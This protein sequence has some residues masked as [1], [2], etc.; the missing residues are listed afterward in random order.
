MNYIVFDLELNS[1]IFKSKLPN[2]IIEI[3]AVKL[4]RCLEEVSTFQ[5]FI[6]P[7]IHRKLFPII[8]RKTG[9]LQA[10]VNTAAGFKEVAGLFRQWIGK[11]YILCTWGHD[12]MHHIRSN[13][14]LNR[15]NTDWLRNCLDI[16]KHFSKMYQSPPGQ[17]FSLK[18]ALSMLEIE[19][20]DELH[21]AEIDAKYTAKVFIE[22]FDR[23]EF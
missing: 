11:D 6:K 3:G 5:S 16:Q 10:D 22:I 13:C 9:I 15:M 4:N 12:D 1:K 8:K 2:E 20:E 21:R 17:R 19:L 14:K 23:L 7:K 18:S